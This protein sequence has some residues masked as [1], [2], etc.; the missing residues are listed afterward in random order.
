[1]IKYTYVT[2]FAAH[3]G[4][5]TVIVPDQVVDA[6]RDYADRKVS[7]PAMLRGKTI[8]VRINVYVTGLYTTDRGDLC[9]VRV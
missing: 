6:K 2:Q 7:F 9:V 1:M 3:L 8:R 5:K 4:D